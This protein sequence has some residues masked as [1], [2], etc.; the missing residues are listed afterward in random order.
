M[1]DMYQARLALER[2][3]ERLRLDLCSHYPEGPDG[4]K[5]V[6]PRCV[7]YR[8]NDERRARRP[9]RVNQ[10]TEYINKLREQR[11]QLKNILGGLRDGAQ[12]V[13]WD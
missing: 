5:L 10:T 11:R 12:E 1:S 9:Q 4:Y 6:A 2:E 13:Q 7:K 8:H 3:R